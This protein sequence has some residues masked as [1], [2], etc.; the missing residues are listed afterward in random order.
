MKVLFN[1]LKCEDSEQII[2]FIHLYLKEFRR[3][4]LVGGA[5]SLPRKYVQHE[6]LDSECSGVFEVRG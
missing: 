6:Y 1:T 5:E 2:L 3:V 4:G